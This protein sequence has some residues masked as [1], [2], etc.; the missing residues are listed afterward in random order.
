MGATWPRH[1]G[2][3]L[4]AW[5]LASSV[6][7]DEPPPLP[8][9][10]SAAKPA[11]GD[12][13]A[14][15]SKSKAD[16]PAKPD[17]AE[18]PGGS[19]PSREDADV[20]EIDPAVARA[21]NDEKLKALPMGNDKAATP[22]TKALREVLEERTAWLDALN[23]AEKERQE[24]ENPKPSP[25]KLTADA[26]TEFE[27]IK[28]ILDQAAKEPDLLV[29]TAFK[30]LP[31]SATKE[32]ATKEAA[33]NQT[34]MKDAIDAAQ[35]D[36]NDKNAK[37][38]QLRSEQEKK[39]GAALSALRA[40]RDEAF[41]RLAALK[42]R[43]K[44]RPAEAPQAKTPEVRALARE[45]KINSAWEQR[46]ETERL[47][48]KEALL[49][50]E[51]RRTELPKLSGQL[52]EARVRLAQK[53]LDLMNSRL[54]ALAARQEHEL[55]REA[56]KEKTRAA[57]S[58]D[59]LERYRA[60]RTGE[61]LELEARVVKAENAVTTNPRLS[62]EEQKALADSAFTDFTD[63][64]KLLDDGNVSHLDALRLNND[65]R[66][67]GA[68]RAKI[69]RNELAQTANQLATAE[70][71]LSAVEMELIYDARDDQ[72]EIENLFDQVPLDARPKARA[73][74]DE[75]E[76]KHHVLL[77]RRR[78]A[79]QKLAG[80]AEDTHAQV[81]R[82]LGILDQHYGF[83]RTNLFWVRDEEPVGVATMSTSQRELTQIIRAGA[84]T[85]GEVADRKQWGRV[86]PE[87]LVAAFGLVVLPWPLRRLRGIL[88]SVG[89][90]PRHA[91]LDEKA[92]ASAS[93][94]LM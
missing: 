39:P 50:L 20:S 44:E 30:N 85:A 51:V 47:K 83:I 29:P 72:Y 57:K 38:D 64:K 32:T 7:A 13:A 33:L 55:R 6:A 77:E 94:P 88:H 56:V 27:R 92:S 15:P 36:L 62:Y 10:P 23:K 18:K 82:R 66:R 81:V 78:S 34:E 14:A 71:A 87:F 74:F 25:E 49:A 48:G 9:L 31:A 61:L 46:V 1:L 28:S 3:V 60:R 69:V 54:R 52:L 67:I 53:T 11:Q 8:S 37:L 86:S 4:A 21:E 12:D 89:R 91:R 5:G 58:D 75:F 65:F 41:Q 84:K 35:S 70:N 59:P 40:R 2:A 42:A 80:K 90:L 43:N 22:A 16:R 63:I 24:A 19:E 76:R 73:L 26:K 68:Q 79:L 45:K 93:S 17:S